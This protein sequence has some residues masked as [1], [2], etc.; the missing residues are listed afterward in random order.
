[1]PV[2]IRPTRF[3]KRV[4]GV[5]VIERSGY[6]MEPAKVYRCRVCGKVILRKKKGKKYGVEGVMEKIR[7]HYKKYHPKK[8]REMI[9]KGVK[10]RM[11]RKKNI[12]NLLE[13]VK[14]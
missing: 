13:V 14:K 2:Y 1:M 4:D 5:R 11:E 12:L 9:E 3:L 6:W 8:F 10:T 7:R